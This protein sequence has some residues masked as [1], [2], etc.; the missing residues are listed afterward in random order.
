MG[1]IFSYEEDIDPHPKTLKIRHLL[2]RQIRDSKLRLKPLKYGKQ[3]KKPKRL[4]NL[5]KSI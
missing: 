5:K 1:N 3:Q 2:L 4:N